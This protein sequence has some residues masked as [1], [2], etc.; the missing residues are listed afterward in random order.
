MAVAL[1][2]AGALVF[3]RSPRRRRRP[4]AARTPATSALV[5]PPPVA[6][7]GSLDGD[8][9][10]AAGPPAGPI[11]HD[12]R[13]YASLGLAYVAQGQ[14]HRRPVLVP[15]GRGG[16]RPSRSASTEATTSRPRSGSGSLALARHDFEAALEQGRRAARAE[17]VLGRRVRRDRGRTGRARPVRGRAFDAFQTMVDTRPDLASYARVVYA[18]ELRRRRPRRGSARCGMAFDAAGTPSDAAW[19][20]YQLGEL[21]FGRRRRRGRPREWYAARARPRSV[22]RAEPRRAR[23]GRVGERRRRPRDRPVH[24]R[25][26]PLPL[27]RVRRRARRPVRVTRAARP[28]PTGRRRSWR[29][30]TSSRPPTA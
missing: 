25:R 2:V 21:A 10:R 13:G 18:R 6:A 30:C 1:L 20:A 5:R 17:P 16:A 3:V 23:Q 11:P 24:G 22:V 29:R 4:V 9:R 15:E 8:D 14:G 26:R 27:R 19:A 12:W 28:R 7:P